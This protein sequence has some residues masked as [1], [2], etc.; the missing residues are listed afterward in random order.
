MRD[1]PGELPNRFHLL[2]LAELLF[3]MPLLGHIP[4]RSPHPHQMPIFDKADDVIKEDAGSPFAVMLPRFRVRHTIARPEKRTN[5]LAIGGIGD[6]MEVGEPCPDELT[7]FLIPVHS[8]HR[9]VAFRD[10]RARV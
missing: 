1:T 9:V 7:R 4:L 8:R 6:V 10:A 5:L 3:E 2:R